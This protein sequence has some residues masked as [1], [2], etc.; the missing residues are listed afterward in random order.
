MSLSIEWMWRNTRALLPRKSAASMKFTLPRIST[1]ATANTALITPIPFYGLFYLDMFVNDNHVY[2]IGWEFLNLF[3][4]PMMN[5]FFQVVA[6]KNER[7]KNIHRGLEPTVGAR[8]HRGRWVYQSRTLIFNWAC[9]EYLK[10]TFTWLREYVDILHTTIRVI[11][12]TLDIR[13][14]HAI[15]LSERNLE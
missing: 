5:L 12:E 9:K 3:F 8:L 7:Q 1:A 11:F 2:F 6:G 14:N 4:I 15:N 10:N 13:D